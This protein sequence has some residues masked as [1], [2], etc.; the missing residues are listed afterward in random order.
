VSHNPLFARISH[1]PLFIVIG[2]RAV[3]FRVL[4]LANLVCF[5]L[6]VLLC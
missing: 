6:R 3:P 5:S 2:F 1:R 4:F